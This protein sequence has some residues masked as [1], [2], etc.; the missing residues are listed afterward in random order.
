MHRAPANQDTT[1]IFVSSTL[2]LPFSIK[3]THYRPDKNPRLAISRSEDFRNR[4]YF[5]AI[6]ATFMDA[7]KVCCVGVLNP[8]RVSMSS[9]SAKV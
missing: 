8:A 7:G 6:T 5:V 4:S 2:A 3:M 9:S 1:G